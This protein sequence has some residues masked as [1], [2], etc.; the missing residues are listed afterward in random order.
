[1]IFNLCLCWY[2]ITLEFLIPGDHSIKTIVII[3]WFC[4]LFVRYWPV[5]SPNDNRMISLLD[6]TTSLLAE[7]GNHWSTNTIFTLKEIKQNKYACSLDFYS[8][9]KRN[10]KKEYS[11]VFVIN[12]LQFMCFFFVF[13]VILY[14]ICFHYHLRMFLISSFRAKSYGVLKVKSLA[15]LFAPLETKYLTMSIIP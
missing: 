10:K 15:F 14:L 1:M 6:I 2:L 3:L 12:W 4:C 9:F 11:T 7:S 13:L 8:Y 5:L